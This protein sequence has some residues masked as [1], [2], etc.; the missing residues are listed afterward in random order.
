MIYRI[1]RRLR[2]WRWRLS[3]S[4]WSARLLRLA[5]SEG[6]PTR[7]GLV[8]IQIDGLARPQL[9]DAIKRRRMPFLR[10]LLRKEHYELHA[11]FSGVPSNTPSVQGEL[12][13]GARQSVP[14]FAFYHK[15]AGR[16]FRMYEQQSAIQTEGEMSGRGEPLL[17]DGTAYCDVYAGGAQE[18]LCCVSR[19]G[20]GDYLSSARPLALP[21]LVLFNFFSIIRMV[22]NIGIE[23][24]LALWDF[25]RGMALGH[26]IYHELRF[27]FTRVVITSLMRDLVTIGA[28]IDVA[29]G[30]PIIH[31]NFLGYDEQAHRRGPSSAFAHWTLKGID[32]SI[33]HIWHAARNASARDYDVWIYSDHGQEDTIPF[34]YETGRSIEEAVAEVY[35]ECRLVLDFPSSSKDGHGI[36]H[37]RVA[38]LGGRFS[39]SSPGLAPDAPSFVVEGLRMA[40]MGPVG[41][42]YPPEPARDHEERHR[43]AVA[44][45]QVAQVPLVLAADGP[46]RAIAWNERGVWRLPEQAEHVLGPQHP[47]LKEAAA[48]LVDLLAHPNAGEFMISGWRMD[49]RK[50]LSFP[51]ENGAHAG[52][53][54][55]ETDAFALL[56]AD[57]PIPPEATDFLRPIHLRQMALERLGRGQPNLA[58]R[59]PRPI[60]EPGTLRIMTYNIHSCIGMDGKISPERIA[61]LIGQ[62]DPDVVALQEV[63]VA[64]RRTGFV[65]Q[66]ELI[67]HLLRMHFDFHASLSVEEEQYG[68]AILSRQPMTRVKGGGLPTLP[69]RRDIEPRGAIWVRIDCD[70]A[71]IDLINTHLGLRQRERMLQVEALLGPDWLGGH[72]GHPPV[73]LCGDFNAFPRSDVYRR[74]GMRMRDAQRVLESHRPHATWFGRYPIGRID[75]V[76]LDPSLN[77]VNVKVGISRLAQVASD[78]L[79]LMVDIRPPQSTGESSDEAAE[80]AR[81]TLGHFP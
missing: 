58:H 32:T 1:E 10:R 16:I 80:L 56:P 68:I 29:R 35:Q 76:F 54:S 31:L 41:W 4:D 81:H 38:M 74:L 19:Y 12:F 20:I 75:H 61:R 40:A 33:R 6:P 42:I 17:K 15:A 11:H 71:K 79:P 73:V 30:M 39:R 78:H 47:Y 63:D 21:F 36:Q 18:A 24:L 27:I 45:V 52:P 50:P 34:P 55:R 51:I 5:R 23:F 3:R 37:R 77:V 62:H 49:G 72:A 46:G 67:A 22:F 8:M 60:R 44:L 9:L 64:R 65:D 70:G 66:A 26:S 53:G 57:T 48:S 13:Y 69:G 43:T 14:A 59:L 7:P 25:F 2:I 28:K